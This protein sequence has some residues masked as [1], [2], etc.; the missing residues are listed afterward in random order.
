MD[1]VGKKSQ[2]KA[3][4]EDK[5]SWLNAR[6]N[7]MMICSNRSDNSIMFLADCSLLLPVSNILSFFATVEFSMLLSSQMRKNFPLSS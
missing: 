3:L 1:K 7:S 2:A 6:R 4:T 5:L